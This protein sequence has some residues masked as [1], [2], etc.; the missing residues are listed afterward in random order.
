MPS[1]APTVVHV[2]PMA[3][4]MPIGPLQP[5]RAT[6]SN[7]GTFELG[8]SF[9]PDPFVVMG[10]AGGAR[11]ASNLDPSCSG[12]V[13]R[14]PDHVFVAETHYGSLRVLAAAPTDVTLVIEKPDGTYFCNDD[15]EGTNPVIG[16][17]FAAGRYKLWVGSFAQIH[18]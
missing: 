15:G 9:K 4:L 14:T 8:R 5:G 16:A 13:S 11:N 6:K 17:S 10:R 2:P 12:W 18:F 3:Q 1:A 7:F